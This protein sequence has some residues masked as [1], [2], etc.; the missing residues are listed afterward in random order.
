M[1]GW[2]A[3]SKLHWTRSVAS[4]G[5]TMKVLGRKKWNG[6]LV[7]VNQLGVLEGR[8]AGVRWRLGKWAA[9]LEVELVDNPVIAPIALEDDVVGRSQPEW[10][11]GGGRWVEFRRQGLAN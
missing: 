4:S 2:D 11:S 8:D 9:R 6:S 7:V 1:F 10:I 3:G 5:I